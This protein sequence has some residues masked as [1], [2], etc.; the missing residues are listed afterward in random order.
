MSAICGLMATLVTRSYAG[1]VRYTG[2][3]DGKR[4]AISILLSV[5]F[6]SLGNL[7][8]YYNMGRNLLPYSVMLISFPVSFLLL[9]FYRLFVKEIFSFV[10]SSSVSSKKMNVLLFGAGNLGLSVKQILDSTP[11]SGLRLAAILEDDVNKVGK[12]IQGVR[13]YSASQLQKLAVDHGAKELIVAVNDLATDR[14]NMLV[15]ECLQLN[16]RV[17]MVPPM[18]R[19][20]K[21]E[22]SLRQ[23]R[24]VNIEDLLGRDVISLDNPEIVREIKGRAVCITG[25][26]GSIG[27]ELARQIA[28]L[29][30][31]RLVLVDQAETP[32]FEKEFELRKYKE[33]L[34]L[35]A[36]VGDVTNLGRMRKIFDDYRPELVFHAAAYKHVPLME[37]N[38]VEAIQCNIFG[39]KTVADLSVEFGVKK[40]VMISTDKA[41]N[42]TSV[43][44]C[45]K[46]IAEIYV[47]SLSKSSVYR[48]APGTVFVTTR[49]GNVLGSNGSVIPLFKKQMESG[50][51]IT[52]THPEIVRYFM[53]IPEACHLVLEAGVMGNASEVYLFDMGR[54]VKIYDLAKKMVKLSGLELGKDIDI[55]FSGLREGEKLFE[56]LLANSENTVPTHHQKILKAVVAEYEYERISNYLDIMRDLIEDKNELKIV[57]LMKD[58]VP[59]YKSAVSR[60]QILD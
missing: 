13:I 54:P 36:C 53:T 23:I 19:W 48:G 20:M 42:P 26:A 32:L 37:A 41:V 3:E 7:L 11:H 35:V 9:F 31:R 46:R 16:I 52:V 57:A 10:K 12:K 2:I 60:F 21:G 40:F 38:P 45:S 18:D 14:K 8:Y 22:L 17:R 29:H 4:I 33:V 44:G 55:V 5:G 43:M 56:E 49:F 1:I 24:E 28:G 6:M 27:G 51:P 59:E 25:A 30:P 34:D 58:I 39:T 47:Q 15:E 50:G